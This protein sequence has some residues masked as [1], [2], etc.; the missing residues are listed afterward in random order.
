MKTNAGI[1]DDLP[2]TDPMVGPGE[3]KVELGMRFE[4]QPAVAHLQ[5]PAWCGNPTDRQMADRAR[6]HLYT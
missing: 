3:A 2:Q 6:D 1:W 5:V 4:F